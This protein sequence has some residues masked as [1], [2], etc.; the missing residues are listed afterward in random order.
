VIYGGNMHEKDVG[1][2]RGVG[3]GTFGM[4]HI[5]TQKNDL[6]LSLF[7]TDTC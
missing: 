2:W 1:G 6:K 5:T 3:W 7:R 4:R